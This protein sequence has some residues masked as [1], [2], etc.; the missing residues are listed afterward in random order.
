MHGGPLGCFRSGAE[1]HAS[2][3]TGAML[4]SIHRFKTFGTGSRYDHARRG[5]G[6][7]GQW[8][9]L[10]QPVPRTSCMLRMLGIGQPYRPVDRTLI[11]DRRSRNG[12]SPVDTDQGGAQGTRGAR[13][14]RLAPFSHLRLSTTLSLASRRGWPPRHACHRES[15]IEFELLAQWNMHDWVKLVTWLGRKSGVEMTPKE[16]VDLVV[17]RW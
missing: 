13:L 3:K 12:R 5:Q 6:P 16:D 7:G 15:Y 8:P 14:A 2:H 4:P 17:W 9:A 1:V 10:L 11:P